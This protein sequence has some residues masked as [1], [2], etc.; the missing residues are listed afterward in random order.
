MNLHGRAA[1]DFSSLLGV[2]QMV[3]GPTHI[4]GWGLDL[5]LIDVLI[6]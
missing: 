5:A 4:D 1:L 2:E 6:F 3:T